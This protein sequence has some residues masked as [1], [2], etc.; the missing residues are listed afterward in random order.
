M[1]AWQ[2]PQTREVMPPSD[3]KVVPV[4]Q[5]RL[6]HWRSDWQDAPSASVPGGLL[7]ASSSMPASQVAPFTALVQPSSVAGEK[8]LP[9]SVS[10]LEQ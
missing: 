3:E 5:S 1:R 9:G 10:A 6:A 4:L 7:Q 8:V 2:V